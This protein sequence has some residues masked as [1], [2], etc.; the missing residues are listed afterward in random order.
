MEG[1]C[2]RDQIRRKVKVPTLAQPARMGHPPMNP[3]PQE[4]IG[5]HR[6]GTECTF[7]L[8]GWMLEK[9]APLGRGEK[10]FFLT[11]LFIEPFEKPNARGCATAQLRA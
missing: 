9:S 6:C 7:V 3:E 10:Y 1:L 8:R 4:P 11:S 2:G 5:Q